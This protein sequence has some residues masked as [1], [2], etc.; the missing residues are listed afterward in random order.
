M[1]KKILSLVLSVFVAIGCLFS[2]AGC[3]LVKDNST[4]GSDSVVVSVNGTNYS[5]DDVV[6]NFYNFLYK[7]YALIY[8]GTDSS[9]I[10]EKFYNSFVKDKIVMEKAQEAL[11]DGTISYKEKDAADVWQSVEDY[12]RSQI[13]SYEK[14]LYEDENEY[15]VWLQTVEEDDDEFFESYEDPSKK[16]N[17]DKGADAEKLSREDIERKDDNQKSMLGLV[18]DAMFNYVSDTTEDANGEEIRTYTKIDTQEGADKRRQAFALYMENMFL[19]AKARGDYSSQDKL[20]LDQVVD[21]YD[22]YYDGKIA[23]LYQRYCEE[24]LLLQSEKLSEESI[25]KTFLQSYEADKQNFLNEA[26]YVSVVT[27]SDTELIL[28]HNNDK[29][30]TVQHILLKFDEQLVNLIKEDPYYVDM[31]SNDVQLEIFE[32]FVQNRENIVAD[33]YSATGALT[34]VNEEQ[35]AK[36]PSFNID[37]RFYGYYT[38]SAAEGY[39]KVAKGTEGAKMM[40]TV[41][42]I[43]NCYNHNLSYVMSMVESVLKP[44]GSSIEEQG[45][46]VRYIIE[47]AQTILNSYGGTK[48]YYDIEA[49]IEQKVSSLVFIALSWIYSD[50]G[51]YN[52][53]YKQLGYVMANYP[54][55][56]NGFTHEFVDLSKILYEEMKKG[57]IDITDVDA[58]QNIVMTKDGIHIIKL[59]NIF[60]Q[61]TSLIDISGIDTTNTAAVAKM[62]KETFICNGSDQTVYD[63]YRD[64]IYNNLAGDEATNGTF[65]EDLKNTWLQEFMSENKITYVSKLT[66]EEIMAELY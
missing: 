49:E 11:E 32:Q 7:N 3:S 57:N 38:H 5:K 41:E 65:F 54:D 17:I 48:T 47:A 25:V 9:V 14:D 6:G 36:M 58:A 35:L 64:M 45:E 60:E 66:Y 39:K 28:Y 24:E 56:N 20:M 42:N 2:F 30:F 34:D 22:A 1:K 51:L 40:A 16:N 31:S 43:V 61:G 46:D 21:I 55:D 10:E 44:N 53:I 26:D 18:Y 4:A 15:P 37:E 13:D 12:F 33:Y 59:D 52:T 19:N 27:S 63:Y 23:E 50:D 8:N 29:F 62:M